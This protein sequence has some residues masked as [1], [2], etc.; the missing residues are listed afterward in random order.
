MLIGRIIDREWQWGYFQK[1]ASKQVVPYTDG[2]ALSSIFYNAK[3]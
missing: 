2:I 1:F 3:I